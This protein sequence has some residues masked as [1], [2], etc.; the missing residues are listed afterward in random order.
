LAIGTDRKVEKFKNCAIFWQHAYKTYCLNITN[1]IFSP[2][3]V[4]TL[5][6]FFLF[7]KK[8]LCICH[9]G[10]SFVLPKNRN[11]AS[12]VFK[13]KIKIGDIENLVIFI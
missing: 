5:G 13:I 6:H 9:T 12:E 2:P 1:S 10:F 3:T 8:G 4:A 7:F 11:T